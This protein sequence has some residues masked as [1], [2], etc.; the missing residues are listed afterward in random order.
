MSCFSG[1]FLL[2]HIFQIGCRNL[3]ASDFKILHGPNFKSFALFFGGVHIIRNIQSV[4]S[5]GAFVVLISVRIDCKGC[6][7]S[8]TMNNDISF[9]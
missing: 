5:D 4:I 9:T 3:L 7:M 1:R 2:S 6:G 8:A